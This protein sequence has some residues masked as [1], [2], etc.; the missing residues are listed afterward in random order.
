MWRLVYW[1]RPE[2]CGIYIV[3]ERFFPFTLST[4][5]A[6]KQLSAALSEIT[7]RRLCSIFSCSL[8]SSTGGALS[9]SNETNISSCVLQFSIPS[10]S[11]RIR[12]WI[13]W[14]RLSS[15]HLKLEHCCLLWFL[16]TSFFGSCNIV[17]VPR[18]SLSA[19]S[20]TPDANLD[21]RRAY[22]DTFRRCMALLKV[23]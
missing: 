15:L 19:Q 16:S 18:C 11:A 10:S 5:S 9:S 12:Q 17:P 1:R 13:E 2:K 4:A 22:Y 6:K 23:I 21:C 14:L 20:S 7:T 3:W 8:V